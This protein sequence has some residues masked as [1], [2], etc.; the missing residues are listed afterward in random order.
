M[1]WDL[2]Q[3]SACGDLTRVTQLVDTIGR[4]VTDVMSH[5]LWTACCWGDVD[6]VDW[7]VIHTSADVNYGRVGHTSVGSMTSLGVACYDCHVTVVRL[8]LTDATSL[9]DVNVV[10]GE[11]CNTALH[12]VIWYTQKTP[13][14]DSCYRSDTASVVDVMYES[15]VNKHDSGGRT[16]MHI[17]CVNGHLDIVKV[18]LSVFADANMIDC[19]GRTPVAVCEHYGSPELAHYI[20][21]HNHLMYVSGDD[22]DGNIKTVTQKI[23][24]SPRTSHKRLKIKCVTRLLRSIVTFCCRL[25][26]HLRSNNFIRLLLNLAAGFEFILR[27]TRI[28]I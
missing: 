11:T 10:S 9:C 6:I 21:Q 13:L 25:S 23:D 28:L 17:A 3:A 4:D 18:L 8:L 27:Y 14:H 5:A 22:D 19:E 12:D 15:D 24:N 26:L 1:R 7:L 16:A 20:Q 2:V